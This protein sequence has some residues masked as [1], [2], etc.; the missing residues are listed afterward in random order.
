M[1]LP[2]VQ[3]PTPVVFLNESGQILQE[4][5]FHYPN[6]Q[7]LFIQIAL[8]FLVYEQHSQKLKSEQKETIIV[9]K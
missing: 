9:H 4:F 2:R 3:T 8:V 7:D 1:H 6:L 5:H